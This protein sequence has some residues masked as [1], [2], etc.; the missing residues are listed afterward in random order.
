[1]SVAWCGPYCGGWLVAQLLPRLLHGRWQPSLVPGLCQG[2]GGDLGGRGPDRA[3]V[4]RPTEVVERAEADPAAGERRVRSGHQGLGGAVDVRRDLAAVGVVVDAHVVPLGVG[5]G[6]RCAD[7]A[8][9]LV[10]DPAAVGVVDDEDPVVGI[11]RVVLREVRV[12]E[13]LRALV[14]PDDDHVAVAH[15]DRLVEAHLGVDGDV[16]ELG[17]LRDDRVLERTAHAVVGVGA[18]P[19]EHELVAVVVPQVVGQRVPV[20]RRRGRDDVHLLRPVPGLG[21]G[22]GRQPGPRASAPVHRPSPSAI[23]LR[24]CCMCPRPFRVGV[25]GARPGEP[26][27]RGAAPRARRSDA[28]GWPGRRRRRRPRRRR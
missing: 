3:E 15:R 6:R 2:T 5:D 16:G 7:R 26:W 23:V 10:V 11:D 13:A 24:L 27:V 19:G 8:V 4:P 28:R 21:G 17:A 14:V 9:P 1:M 12:V 25:S 22:P 18:R 20:L